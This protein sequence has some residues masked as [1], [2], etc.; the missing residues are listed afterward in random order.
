MHGERE[1]PEDDAGD[2]GEDL[3]DRLD[4]LADPGLAYSER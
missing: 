1:E 3:E 2:A 4:G